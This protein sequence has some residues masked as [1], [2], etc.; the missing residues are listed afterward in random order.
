VANQPNHQLRDFFYDDD[1]YAGVDIGEI[2]IQ[3]W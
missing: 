1:S 2:T 3:K